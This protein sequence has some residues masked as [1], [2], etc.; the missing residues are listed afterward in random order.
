MKVYEA[1][2]NMLIKSPHSSLSPSP[3]APLPHPLR[4]L[5]LPSH[6]LKN[7]RGDPSKEYTRGILLKNIRGSF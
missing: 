3:P 5:S 2:W 6:P 7:I 4:T 1:I